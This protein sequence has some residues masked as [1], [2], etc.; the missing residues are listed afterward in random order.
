MTAANLERV[1]VDDREED[2]QVIDHRQRRVRSQP[3]VNRLQIVVNKWMTE[4]R[5]DVRSRVGKRQLR[6]PLPDT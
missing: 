5:S 4:R 2:L 6:E 3:R 1:D